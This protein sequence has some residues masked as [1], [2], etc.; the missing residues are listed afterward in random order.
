MQICA[1][2][3]LS[4]GLPF[5]LPVQCP[6]LAALTIEFYSPLNIAACRGIGKI[7]GMKLQGRV[8]A[9]VPNSSQKGLSNLLK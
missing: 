1:G 7:L 6:C 4:M 2:V 5:T 8:N 3:D 9:G